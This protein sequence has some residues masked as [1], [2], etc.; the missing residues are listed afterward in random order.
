MA[1]KSFLEG[2]GGYAQRIEYSAGKPVY[3][4]EAPSKYQNDLVST[5]WSIKKLIYSGDDVVAVLWA[6]EDSRFRFSWDNRAIYS[7]GS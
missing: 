6:D 2:R 5:V 3:V 1:Y 7:Y 4:G